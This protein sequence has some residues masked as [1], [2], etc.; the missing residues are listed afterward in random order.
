[1]MQIYNDEKKI[2]MLIQTFTIQRINQRFILTL[3]TSMS[4]LS[5][6]FRDIFQI[7]VQSNISLTKK[8][9]IRS[10]VELGFEDDAILKIIKSLYEIPEIEI[11]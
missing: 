9:F 3:T 8:F 1:M 6:F 2:E 11:H 7:Y 10:F 4:H 5:L